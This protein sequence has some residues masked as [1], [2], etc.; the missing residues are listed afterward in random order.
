VTVSPGAGEWE[1]ELR[2]RS[3]FRS[4]E[5]GR[6][7]TQNFFSRG[8]FALNFNFFNL[9]MYLISNLVVQVFYI[10]SFNH[11]LNFIASLFVY[12]SRDEKFNL[13]FQSP[14]ESKMRQRKCRGVAPPIRSAKIKLAETAKK[15]EAAKN[16]SSIREWTHTALPFPKFTL[17]CIISSQIQRAKFVNVMFLKVK[18]PS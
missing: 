3:D 9:S 12:F 18:N 15:T 17:K 10:S 4:D 2:R 8:K 7:F 11:V 6:D 5:A 16:W 13:Y 14:M 1:T